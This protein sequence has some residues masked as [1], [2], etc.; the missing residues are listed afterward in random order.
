MVLPAGTGGA[1]RSGSAHGPS[2]PGRLSLVPNGHPK[3]GQAGQTVQ[4]AF[5]LTYDIEGKV[6]VAKCRPLMELERKL[7]PFRVQLYPEG[8]YAVP[9]ELRDEMT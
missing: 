6:G 3:A 8:G 9:R 2:I 7:F 4:F 5:V 1:L